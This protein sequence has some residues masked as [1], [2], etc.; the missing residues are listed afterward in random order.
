VAKTIEEASTEEITQTYHQ[1]QAA[2]S[3]ESKPP[4]KRLINPEHTTGTGINKVPEIYRPVIDV[5]R[6]DTYNDFARTLI[7][8]T[9]PPANNRQSQQ[10]T[11]NANLATISN[12]PFGQNNAATTQV[13]K[14]NNARLINTDALLSQIQTLANVIQAS[15]NTENNT[16]GTSNSTLLVTHEY[17]VGK[18]KRTKI[19]PRKTMNP[20]NLE[21]DTDDSE[22]S[23]D[24]STDSDEEFEEQQLENRNFLCWTA[25]NSWTQIQ[26]VIR[27]LDEVDLEEYPDTLLGEYQRLTTSKEN[28]T[29]SNTTTQ[30]GSSTGRARLNVGVD[31]YFRTQPTNAKYAT[32][33]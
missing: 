28:L 13:P 30:N 11:Y 3:V 10:S 7:T 19:E 5:A 18:C 15:T 17:L 12:N 32:R 22:L 31:V 33:N 21:S 27:M 8:Q 23:D 1:L 29:K 4:R 9:I 6:L 26:T 24:E 2:P 20:I 25:E 16:H 14:A